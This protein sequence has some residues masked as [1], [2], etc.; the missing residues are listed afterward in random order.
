MQQG[1]QQNRCTKVSKDTA[2]NHLFFVM[3][4]ISYTLEMLHLI[5]LSVQFG[6]AVEV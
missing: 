2:K 6:M 5:I 4:T 3:Y 1:I